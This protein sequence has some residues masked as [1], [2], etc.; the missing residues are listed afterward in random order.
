MAEYIEREKILA[1]YD[2]QHKGP[3]GGARKIMETYPAA[4][5]EPVRRGRWE[6]DR[7]VAGKPVWS[8][9]KCTFQTLEKTPHC[10]ICGAKMEETE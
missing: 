2:R 10:P 7:E 4:D 3:A 8:C 6:T 9:S 1:E 5:V